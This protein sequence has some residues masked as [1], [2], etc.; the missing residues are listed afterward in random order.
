MNLKS[1]WAINTFIWK[2]LAKKVNWVFWVT[3]SL[4]VLESNLAIPAYSSIFQLKKSLA[5]F[6]LVI[7]K[8]LTVLLI[9]LLLGALPAQAS[10]CK[11]VD[12]QKVCILSIERSAKKYWEYQVQLSVD[13]IVQ[14][15]TIYNCRKELW[16]QPN[17][18][19]TRFN[20]SSVNAVACSLFRHN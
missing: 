20:G 5:K 11:S 15:R 2:R 4:L 14:P 18:Q 8:S 17:G 13:R 19:W 3:G 10:F 6:L 1:S 9:I 7:V 16:L 12:T